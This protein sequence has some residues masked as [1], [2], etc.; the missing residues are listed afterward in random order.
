VLHRK[1]I[2]RTSTVTSTESNLAATPGA[3][4]LPWISRGLEGLWLTAAFLVPLM[5][6]GQEYAISEAQIAY[7]EVP[8]VALLRTLAGLMAVLWSIEWAIKSQ[9]SLSALPPMANGA[10]VRALRP[11]N[12]A[13]AITNWLKLH[14]TRWV[15]L[16][17]GLFFALT[18]L[19]TV[20]SGAFSVSVWGEIPGQDG[21]SAYTITSYCILFLVIATHLKSQAQFG[22]LLGAVVL[23][24]FLIG[25]YG[26]LQHYGH[27]FFNI[28]DSIGGG[29]RRVTVFMGN[30]IFA[31]AVLA[32]TVPATLVAAAINLHDEN[33]RNWGPLSKLGQ[34]GRDFFLTSFWALVLA[35]QLVG[36]MLTFSRG[37]WAGA[38]LALLVFLGLVVPLGWRVLIRI[39]LVLGLGGVLSVAFLHWQGNVS[40]L[41]VGP[42]LG[43]VIALLGWAGTIAT[44]FIVER[45]GRATV[46]ITVLAVATTAVAAAVIVPSALPDGGGADSAGTEAQSGA[47]SGLFG[48]QITSIKTDVLGGFTGGRGTH[49][50]VSWRLIKDRPWAEFDDL[51]FSW[52]RPFIGYG[53]DLFRYT[54]LLKSTPEVYGLLPFEPDHAHNFFIHQT[55]EQGIFGGITSLALFASVFGVAGHLLLRR[56][57]TG[58]PVYRLLL[59]G[60]MAIIFG[61]FLEMMVGVAR[62]SDLTVLWVIFGLFAALVNLDDGQ[63]APADSTE[64]QT[65]ERV[66]R[67]DRRRTARASAPRS[68]ST[69]LVIRLAI[70]AWLVGGIGVVTWQKSIN[71]VRASVAEGQ[72]LRHF[73]EGDLASTVELLDKAVKLAPGVPNYY[74]NRAQVFLVYQLNPGVLTEPACAAQTQNHYLVC[75]GVKSLES[76]IEATA[77]QPLNFRTWAAAGNSAFNLQL[78]DKAV[79]FYSHAANLVP[80]AWGIRNDLAES[81][82]DANRYEAALTELAWSLGIT[83]DLAESRGALVLKGRALRGLGRLDDALATINLAVLQGGTLE[84]AQGRLALFRDILTERGVLF[85]IGYFDTIIE[86]NP[87]DAVSFYLRGLAHLALG[88]LNSALEDIANSHNLGLTLSEVQANRGYT[89]L[90]MGDLD[91]ARDDLSEALE[92]APGNALINAY[93]GEYLLATG[94]YSQALNYLENA[95]IIDSDLGL[96]YLIRGKLYMT[97]GLEES[98]MEVFDS[99][100]GL[101]LPNA[102][103][104]VE[105]GQIR[106]FFGQHELAFADLSEAI[107]INPNSANYYNARAKTYA[108]K[109]DFALALADF[110]TALQINSSIREYFINRGVLYDILGDAQRS[111]SDFE[112]ARSLGVV[113]LPSANNRDPSYFAVYTDTP[114]T[115]ADAR[116]LL[117][118]QTE[119]QAFRDIEYHSTVRPNDNQYPYSLQILGQTYLELESWGD[120]VENLSRLISLYPSTPETY[121]YRGDAY[122]ALKRYDEAIDDYEKSVELAPYD[123]ANL[124]ARGKGYAKIEQYELAR[125]D[126]NEAIEL[127]PNLS[128]AYKF[129][130]YL[131]VQTGNHSMALPDIDKA[132]E[133]SHINHDA[134]FKRYQVHSGLG[135]TAAALEDLEQAI[136]LDPTNSSYL[137][138]RGLLRYALGDYR[139]AIEDFSAAIAVKDGFAHVDP[140]HSRPFIDRGR[141]YL[142]IASPSQAEDDAASAIKLLSGN[143]VMP[144]WDSYRPSINL[145]LVD[146]QQLLWS[147]LDMFDQEGE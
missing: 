143:L 119:T 128:D 126:F 78:H 142:Q 88:N 3:I 74:N 24:G 77:Q 81:L 27:D 67:R 83:G 31:G 98:A 56:R 50:K 131:S 144:E 8:K 66:S 87:Q 48:Q 135:R 133:L 94:D 64:S 107:R 46:L 60:L 101:D 18:F 54:Y 125:N 63:Q 53:P 33:W 102:R 22:R 21:Y 139:S 69:G 75:L 40:I 96:A 95:N 104:Y 2:V 109:G 111:A 105:R 132:I 39:G 145:L 114:S 11:S 16:A 136:N 147:A 17:A 20:F 130:G 110:D 32:M 80:N 13:S 116:Q 112:S 42:W 61:R 23:M 7:V 6:L 113:N 82:I 29:G 97:L 108:N 1:D 26:I 51:S 122:L 85:D 43:V 55:V 117:K 14:P 47:T 10:L 15:L 28:S 45:F 89:V 9:A 25:L 71:S 38:V 103:D 58:N 68:L 76:N 120:A 100:V 57:R 70:V 99:S 37:P 72:A 137:Y 35:C 124:V 73:Q 93:F 12:V 34:L 140:R 141:A 4:L 36:L 52:L 127:D 30:T 134:Y 118:L 129:R 146:A 123:T 138:H 65:P 115:E 92:S 49:W 5:F 41:G 59:L 106:A 79:D 91:I 90:K 19:S 62:I 86:E 121:R 84:I 44:L